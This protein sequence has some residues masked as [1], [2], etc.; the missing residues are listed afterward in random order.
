M[1]VSSPP[2]PLPIP[3]PWG[4]APDP[5]PQT[6]EG[7]KYSSPGR[8]QS[9]RLGAPPSGSWGSLR[10]RPLRPIAGV[11]GRSSQGWDG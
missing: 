3:I 11:W 7:L 8:H 2:P 9:A 6:P 5:A 10:T 4:S 1:G